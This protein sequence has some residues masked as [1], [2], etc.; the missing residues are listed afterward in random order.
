MIAAN[1]VFGGVLVGRS[2]FG[3]L[4][5]GSL[6]AYLLFQ[7]L[8]IPCATRVHVYREGTRTPARGG[9]NATRHSVMGCPLAMA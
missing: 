4:I 9:E 7:G 3:R 6:G 8:L 1:V 5:E 2:R